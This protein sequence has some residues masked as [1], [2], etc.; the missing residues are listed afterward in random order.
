MRGG[1]MSKITKADAKMRKST[2]KPQTAVLNV[3]DATQQPRTITVRI[4]E[5]KPKPYTCTVISS[6]ET[7][8]L[9]SVY[10]SQDP[11]PTAQD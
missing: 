6:E 2:Q 8:V 3:R 10:Y 9:R 11:E 1:T 4:T 7:I 5:I